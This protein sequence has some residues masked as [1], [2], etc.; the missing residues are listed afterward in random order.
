MEFGGAANLMG[1]PAGR[2]D[3][4]VHV[5]DLAQPMVAGRRYTPSR[6]APLGSLDMLLRAHGMDGAILVQPSFLGEDNGYLLQALATARE[7]SELLYR[8]VA[9]TS[10]A[11]SL[12]TVQRL[13]D[14]GVV[15]MRLNLVGAALPDLASPAWRAHLRHLSDRGWHIELHLER[16]RLG[17]FLPALI[18]QVG[19]V[20]V[21]HFGLPASG[22]SDPDEALAPLLA[23]PPERLMVKLSAPYRFAGDLAAADYG[24][25]LLPLAVRLAEHLGPERLIWGSDWP[26]TRF[27]AGRTYRDTLAWWAAWSAQSA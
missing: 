15:G 5:F 7:T 17:A 16:A 21:D 6:A 19:T 27:E 8:G 13:A 14:G 9:M 1:A 23:T 10:P 2:Y 26:W 12:E 3:G 4:H 18:A 11:T 22:W 20:V 24:G 25:A